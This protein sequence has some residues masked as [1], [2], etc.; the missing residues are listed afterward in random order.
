MFHDIRHQARQGFI[1]EEEAS[2]TR[3]GKRYMPLALQL[4]RNPNAASSP[5]CFPMFSRGAATVKC[6]LK[7]TWSGSGLETGEVIRVRTLLLFHFCASSLNP[8]VALSFA[9]ILSLML[10]MH[11]VTATPFSNLFHLKTSVA[12]NCNKHCI[13]S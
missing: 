2:M 9:R 10:T 1:P 7:T 4:Q 13:A 11:S 5:E 6:L 12:E 8:A 3:K